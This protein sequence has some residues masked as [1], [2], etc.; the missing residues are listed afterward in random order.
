[1]CKHKEEQKVSAMRGAF[2]V[3]K[4]PNFITKQQ[5]QMLIE[6]QKHL[7]WKD[8]YDHQ[9]Q[10][11]TRP[12]CPL[13]PVPQCHIYPFVPPVTVT[14]IPPGQPVPMAHQG[15]LSERALFGKKV[16]SARKCWHLPKPSLAASSCLFHFS[17]T[18]CARAIFSYV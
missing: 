14:P 12:P 3:A 1:M 15:A 2:F 6:S 17:V 11:S 7:G 9:V 8:H 5:Q 16:A 4:V 13:N 18:G 10:P